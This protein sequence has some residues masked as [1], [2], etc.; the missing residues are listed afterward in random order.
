MKFIEAKCVYCNDKINSDITLA[1]FKMI[2]F[3]YN[4]A[5]EY[6]YLIECTALKIPLMMMEIKKCPLLDTSTISPARISQEIDKC[7]HPFLISPK[8]AFQSITGLYLFFEFSNK[9]GRAH[10]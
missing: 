7:I 9:I 1:D 10:V 4:T 6:H 5:Y 3:I 2:K 8:F